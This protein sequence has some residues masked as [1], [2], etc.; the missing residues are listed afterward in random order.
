MSDFTIFLEKLRKETKYLPK[1][2]FWIGHARKTGFVFFF[3]IALARILKP[4]INFERVPV[5]NGLKWSK[6]G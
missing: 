1:R 4:P 5:Q 3:F 2:K 6:I